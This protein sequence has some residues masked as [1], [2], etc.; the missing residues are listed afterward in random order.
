[1]PLKHNPNG[2]TE[3]RSK[4]GDLLMLLP[5]RLLI[6]LRNCAL[7]DGLQQAQDERYL[8]GEMGYAG[9]KPYQHEWSVQDESECW[10]CLGTLGF[11]A[12]TGERNN[13]LWHVR[14][15]GKPSM[16]KRSMVTY[17]CPACQDPRVRLLEDLR[18]SGIAD[19]EGALIKT[20]HAMPGRGEMEAGIR[21]LI[22]RIEL[23]TY[24]GQYTLAGPF[25]CGK[26]TLSQHVVVAAR[27]ANRDAIY[28]TAERFKDAATEQ[29]RNEQDGGSSYIQRIRTAPIVVM[30]QIDWI[31]EITSGGQQ[32]Y[33]AE[34]FRDVFN[35]RYE[36][37]RTHCTVYV[38]NLQAWQQHGAN[39]LAAIYDRM[40]DGVV[41]V[42]NIKDTR[43]TL[44][45]EAAAD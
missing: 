15:D 11:M 5:T 19:P 17:P 32:S 14:T 45:G 40:N 37:R 21:E 9:Q 29:I 23:D 16:L 1:M 38:V 30:D 10:N 12:P 27:K 3:V 36:L 43:R 2:L 35:H 8:L 7:E 6:D 4:V 18:R 28:V 41:L 20:I 33:T 13:G 34:V 42:A 31:R 39:A 22:K 26:S 24:A 25:G 44:Q